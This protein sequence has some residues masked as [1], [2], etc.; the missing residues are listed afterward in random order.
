VTLPGA[1]AP[2]STALGVIRARK[3]P[4]PQQSGSPWRGMWQ[5]FV[6]WCTAHGYGM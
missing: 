3:P 6:T 5:Y 4:H 2:A 1:Y